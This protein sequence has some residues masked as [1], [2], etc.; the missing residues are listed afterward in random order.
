MVVKC[1]G[2]LQNAIDSGLRV[3]VRCSKIPTMLGVVSPLK[4]IAKPSLNVETIN[5]LLY[6]FQPFF[7]CKLL[8]LLGKKGRFFF[9]FRGVVGW[10]E[11][12]L[13]ILLKEEKLLVKLG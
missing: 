11:E 10:L 4:L 3:I 12:I 1:K 9:P 7:R 13:P 5:I 2:I 6:S 8:V